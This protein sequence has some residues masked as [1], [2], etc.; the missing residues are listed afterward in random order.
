MQVHYRLKPYIPPREFL[1]TLPFGQN[2]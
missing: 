1:A 2:R